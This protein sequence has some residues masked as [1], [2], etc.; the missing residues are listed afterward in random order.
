MKDEHERCVEF[1]RAEA[2]A[3]GA[4]AAKY[5]AAGYVDT[6]ARFENKASVLYATALRLFKTPSASPRAKRAPTP[7][8]KRAPTR[9]A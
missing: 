5:R 3:A 7:T 9:P 8:T 2:E 4:N 6:A 1:V